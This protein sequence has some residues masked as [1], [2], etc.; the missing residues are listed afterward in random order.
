MAKVEEG[1][2]NR[3]LID[4]IIFLTAAGTFLLFACILIPI[5]NEWRNRR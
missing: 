2:M 3:S 5:W 4:V 1:V